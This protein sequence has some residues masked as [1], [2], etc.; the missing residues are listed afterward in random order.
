VL[1][2]LEI[3]V[4]SVERLAEICV[5][6]DVPLILDPAPAQPLSPELLRRVQWI[7]PNETEAEFY[8]NRSGDH[9]CGGSD[10]VAALLQT[11]HAVMAQGPRN[12][13]L[14]LGS[15]GAYVVSDGVAQQ[16]TAPPVDVVDTTAAGDALN[17]AFAVAMMLGKTP[18]ESVQFAVAAASLSVTR[19]GAQP[20][21]PTMDEVSQLRAITSAKAWK[22][23]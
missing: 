1:A 18:L 8:S 14:K 7:T 10:A 13:I 12:V 3:P 22:I 11:A 23:T 5:E 21:M 17:G 16:V 2:Q 15:R 9:D 20:S 6:A 19:S 4:E